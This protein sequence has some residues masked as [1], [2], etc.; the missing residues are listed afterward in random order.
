M[1]KSRENQI[2]TLITHPRYN[3]LCNHGLFKHSMFSGPGD[4]IGNLATFDGVTPRRFKF[5]QFRNGTLDFSLKC[6]QLFQNDFY[7]QR[8]ITFNAT[9]PDQDRIYPNTH[10]CRTFFAGYIWCDK[11]FRYFLRLFRSKIYLSG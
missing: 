6:I 3:S 5:T 9:I 2:Q 7:K 11:L 10:L 4:S 8:Y 1:P